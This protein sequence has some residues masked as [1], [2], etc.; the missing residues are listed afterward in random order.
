MALRLKTTLLAATLLA[1]PAVSAAAASLSSTVYGPPQSIGVVNLKSLAL[2]IAS[3]GPAPQVSPS[4]A[5]AAA[6]KR[7]PGFRA[8]PYHRMPMG[9]GGSD[10][11]P[12]A[13]LHASSI[14]ALAASAGLTPMSPATVGVLG[15]NGLDHF[16]QRNA[17]NG[18]QF[19]LE[20]P[21]QALAVGNGYVV[22]VV[23]N[24]LNVYDTS[25]APLLAAPV[26][27]NRFFNQVSEI[28]RSNGNQQ[29]PSLSDPRAYYD[30]DLK[31]FFVVEWA[32]LNDASGAPLNIS[33]QFVAVSTTSDP[34]GTYRIYSY[35]TTNAGVSGCPCFP[36]YQQIGLDKNG[37]YI[38]ANL[39]GIASG[40]F[41]GVKIYAL[42]KLA[43]ANGTPGT[44]AQFRPLPKDFTIHPTVVP[45]G[46]AFASANGGTEYL[47][48]SQAD[49]TATGRAQALN[50]WAISGTS[51]LKTTTPKLT[52]TKTSANTQ[53][54]GN[55]SSGALPPGV[56]ADG[57]RPLGGPSGLNE[58]VPL[59]NA[60]DARV[61]S[62]PVYVNGRVWTV[63]GTAVQGAQYSYN[64]VAWFSAKVAG[65][66]AVTATVDKQGIIQL[67][68]GISLLYPEIVMSVA[69]KGAIGATLT[70]PATFPSTAAILISANGTTGAVTPSGIGA[71]PDDGFTA[72]PQYGGAGVGRWGDYGEGAIDE[73]GGIWLANE[74]IPDTATHPR[75]PLANWGTYL[76]T[77]TP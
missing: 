28:N 45:P 30:S 10:V 17:D 70:G 35:E 12:A 47:V 62:A 66:T 34:T 46:G 15:F 58:P 7:V 5:S 24:G 2:G 73:L 56:Q 16:D 11:S 77:I 39:F 14:S 37:L 59:L 19:S 33:V 75:S 20:P 27:T 29:G 54:Y 25:G 41:A 13:A 1:A 4:A 40:S 68:P 22:E 49:L 52:L 57:P 53:A 31:R 69:G 3:G 76:T 60:D 6:A 65:G 23:N 36:D 48:E 18:N 72:Y 71:L 51:S 32:T 42:P 38:T 8:M 61:S 64:A 55:D 21:D 63:V 43:L 26:S 74:Y 44:I 9:A 67:A 50:F